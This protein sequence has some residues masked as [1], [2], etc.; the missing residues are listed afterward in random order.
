MANREVFWAKVCDILISLV[1]FSVV[2]NYCQSGFSLIFQFIYNKHMYTIGQKLCPIHNSHINPT[3][4]IYF[5]RYV[6]QLKSDVFT[7][8]HSKYL[9]TINVNRMVE[10]N[11][12]SGFVWVG[13]CVYSQKKLF[14]L[15]YDI[16]ILM[17]PLTTV[18]CETSY[19]S[20]NLLLSLN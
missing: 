15:W 5:W 4:C 12:M 2:S 19:I 10:I 13:G 20:V 7:N 14:H 1:L 17:W 16:D 18:Y 8:H 11:V 3:K 9:L 6:L